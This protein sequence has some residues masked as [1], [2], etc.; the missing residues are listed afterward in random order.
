MV[1]LLDFIHKLKRYNDL[2]QHNKQH[3]RKVLLGSV[4]L[5][6][7][8][9][10]FYPQTQKLEWTTSYS[11]INSTTRLLISFHLNGHTWKFHP[12][13]QISKDHELWFCSGVQGSLVNPLTPKSDQH[14]ISPFNITTWPNIQVM[15]ITEMITKDESLDVQT[16][17]PNMY[18]KKYQ[19]N[20]EE[21]THVD[22]GV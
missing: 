13:T 11:I 15:R 8:T 19:E 12:Q 22:I 14:V 17:S 5:N 7:H 4:C 21:N 6:G 20:S 1:T 3:H 10:G 9:L 18:H 2:V 16:N